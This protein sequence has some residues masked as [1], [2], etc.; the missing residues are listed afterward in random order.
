MQSAIPITDTTR[1]FVRFF[2]CLFVTRWYIVVCP[3]TYH[4]GLRVALRRALVLY[5]KVDSQ[6]DKL[7]TVDGRT[8]L[9]TLATADLH[10]AKY[11]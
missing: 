10:F 11:F 6:C 1:L 5:T 8:L 7:A 2:L 3:Q 4:V 9:T